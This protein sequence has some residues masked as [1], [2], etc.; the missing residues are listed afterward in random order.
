MKIEDCYEGLE[1]IG[2]QKASELYVFTVQGTIGVITKV[3]SGMITIETSYGSCVV[4]PTAFEPLISP[5]LLSS[6]IM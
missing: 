6:Y 4:D 1:V 3:W 2:T 5:I